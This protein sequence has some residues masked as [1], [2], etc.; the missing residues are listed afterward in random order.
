MT[1]DLKTYNRSTHDLSY[2]FKTTMSPGTLVP[3]LVEPM[4]P[5]D[6]FDIRLDEKVLTHPTTGPLFGSFKLQ[7]DVFLCPIRLYHA[8]LHNNALNIGL[9]MSS[10]KLPVMTLHRQPNSSIA[11]G[12]NYINPSSLIA[13]LGAMG[14]GSTGVGHNQDIQ[15]SGLPMLM[16]YDIFKNYYANKQEDNAYVVAATGS[17]DNYLIGG[18]LATF[19]ASAFPNIPDI[20]IQ[21]NDGDII[22]DRNYVAEWC[23]EVIGANA[24]FAF[25]YGHSHDL[26]GIE[27]MIYCE[28]IYAGLAHR[29]IPARL[30]FNTIEYANDDPDLSVLVL[31]NVKTRAQLEATPEI[32]D[33]R[34]VM[35]L[36]HVEKGAENM[37]IVP[38]PLKNL[39]DARNQ[40]LATPINEQ[41]DLTA[42]MLYLP[43]TATLGDRFGPGGSDRSQN[44][45]STQAG[46]C[47]KTYQ[48]DI[49]NNWINEDWIDSITGIN[50][51]SSVDVSDGKLSMDALNLA[52]KVYDMLNRIAV[53]GGTYKDWLDTVYTQNSAFMTETPTY[54]GGMSREV[55]FQEVVSN[56]A[57][58]AIDTEPLGSLGGRGV[59]SGRSRE[60][61][62][63]V[64]CYEPSFVMGIVS[65][66]PR[67]DYSQGNRWYMDL[68][69]M[70]DL[71]KPALDGI[72]F[73]DLLGERFAHA[74]NYKAINQDP[75]RVAIGKQPAWLNYM[76]NYNRCYGNF[77][78]PTNEM[79]MTLNRRY[80]Y[81][82]VTN[83]APMEVD[84]TTYIDPRQ[85]NYAFG[86]T[87]ELDAQNFW[88]QLAVN[89]K[90]RRVMSAKIIPNL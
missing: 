50:E 17:G 11:E 51:I 2:I 4:L 56:S 24:T 59:L 75:I 9:N 8:A 22:V 84:A 78:I 55:V 10:V 36:D 53:S 82:G 19:N 20:Q 60:G 77:A 14:P 37:T 26:P 12:D 72:G 34:L 61:N 74:L 33:Y 5:G 66:T 62:I 23:Q 6:T 73:Q 89:I 81:S 80:S 38:F 15:M 76:T 49:F 27:P 63:T 1:V 65:L 48:S 86:V 85:Y 67:L 54:Q 47:V 3:F 21:W 30:F 18:T 58:T 69:N 44:T 46:L 29:W 83:D 7:M 25:S 31:R 28:N 13:Y 71:H 35:G 68:Q 40:I 16:Y 57:S 70:D 39:D 88:T 41:I 43:F 64:R 90:A 79:F 42:D 32:G 52:K 87:T 45:A